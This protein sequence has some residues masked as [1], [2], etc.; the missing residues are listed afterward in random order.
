MNNPT[1]RIDLA[2]AT[3]EEIK[4]LGGISCNLGFEDEDETW[5]D[6]SV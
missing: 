4:A 5:M 2:T 3:D 1:A 6:D